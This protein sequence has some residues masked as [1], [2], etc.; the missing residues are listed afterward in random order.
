[1]KALF[2]PSRSFPECAKLWPSRAIRNEFKLTFLWAEDWSPEIGESLLKVTQL[3][4]RR[5]RVTIQGLWFAV[6]FFF[7]HTKK[8][9]MIWRDFLSKSGIEKGSKISM[10]N[11]GKDESHLFKWSLSAFAVTLANPFTEY[12][13][14][15]G[16]KL[17][18]WWT[19][20]HVNLQAM[21]W[22]RYPFCRWGIW[23]LVRKS[24]LSKGTQVG[25]GKTR[26]WT[27]SRYLIFTL[28][29]VPTPYVRMLSTCPLKLS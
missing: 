2:S 28:S 20:S 15:P 10:E 22:E 7:L 6:L 21:L 5:A 23:G 19:F 16:T 18:A 8:K 11:W 29:Y 13:H 14:H 1:M 3:A 9:N 27:T 4:N 17:S 26:V 12:C 24:N 25:S